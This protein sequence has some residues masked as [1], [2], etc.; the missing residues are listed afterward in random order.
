MRRIAILAL[1]VVAVGGLAWLAFRDDGPAL[2]MEA[3]AACE[4]PQVR[5]PADFV[6]ADAPASVTFA[7]IADLPTSTSMA[8]WPDGRLVVGVREGTVLLLDPDTSRTEEILDITDRI[9]LNAEGGIIGVAM[10]PAAT[11]LY[12]HHTDLDGVS[13]VLSYEIE[14]E[15]IDVRSER[16]LLQV[17]H[18][19]LVHNGGH[20]EFG[21]DG[22]LYLGFGD[23]S[24]EVEVALESD[25][26]DTLAGKLLRIDPT[27][28]AEDPYRIPDDNPDAMGARGR[29]EIWARGLRNPWRFTFDAETGDLWIGDVGND[30]WEEVDVLPAGVSDLDFGWP[31]YEGNHALAETEDDGTSTWPILAIPHGDTCAIVAGAVYRGEEIPELDGLFL[32]QDL[33]DGELRW[34]ERTA[35]GARGGRLGAQQDFPLAFGTDVDGELYLMTAEDGIVRLVATETD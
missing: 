32:F 5:E 24:Q 33:C 21:P 23:G 17:P 12:V 22:Y 4:R 15:G 25:S 26:R 11:H 29:P 7:P 6:E 16:E 8:Q 13:H 14:D 30:C 19:G 31:R 10:D 27:P 1:L 3:I 18:P 34:L 35:D 2:D 20:L 9:A 28:D